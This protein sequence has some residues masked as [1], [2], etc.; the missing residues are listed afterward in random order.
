M[1]LWEEITGLTY[2]SASTSV[3]TTSVNE[4]S[5]KQVSNG[6]ISKQDYNDL[7]SNKD[8]GQNK[9]EIKCDK[10]CND[11]KPMKQLVTES[12]PFDTGIVNV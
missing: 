6:K 5:S 4:N 7:Q 9:E 11:K 1:F 8:D 12:T 2:V 10:N 3:N